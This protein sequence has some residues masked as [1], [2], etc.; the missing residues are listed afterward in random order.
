MSEQVV[1]LIGMVA[2]M[3]FALVLVRG[4]PWGGG[5]R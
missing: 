4:W 2:F 5:E 3:L 1:G